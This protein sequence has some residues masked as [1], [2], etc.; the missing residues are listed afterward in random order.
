M[1]IKFKK[2]KEDE[3]KLKITIDPEIIK[4]DID[5][6]R[7]AVEAIRKAR[8]DAARVDVC[9]L[10]RSVLTRYEEVPF[11]GGTTCYNYEA[12][13]YKAAVEDLTNHILE[14]WVD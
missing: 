9:K 3:R 4:D 2:C 5:E 11:G 1:S 12:H 14:E 7:V 8:K 10:V 13:G 6:E